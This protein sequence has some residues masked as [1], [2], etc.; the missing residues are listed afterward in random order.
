MQS[1]VKTYI[2][3]QRNT[4]SKGIKIELMQNPRTSVPAQSRQQTAEPRLDV[5]EE[6]EKSQA[7]C[8]MPQSYWQNWDFNSDG[9]TITEF[10]PPP[11]PLDKLCGPKPVVAGS[12]SR[13]RRA[14]Q[15]A[16][17]E[18]RGRELSV[19][20]WPQAPVPGGRKP[21]PGV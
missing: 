19:P 8:Q 18:R 20:A 10:F 3:A 11:A 1:T 2:S 9:L 16:E 21:T 15:L 5:E 13:P 12:K 7:T 6:V 17:M 4:T 14:D